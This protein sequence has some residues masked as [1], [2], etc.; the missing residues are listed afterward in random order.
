MFQESRLE[1]L[2]GLPVVCIVVP[3]W[4]V[5]LLEPWRILNAD[6]D[7]FSVGWWLGTGFQDRYHA[8][9]KAPEPQA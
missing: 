2:Q 4:G 7:W 9:G 6:Y 3:F 5:T 1:V 8:E